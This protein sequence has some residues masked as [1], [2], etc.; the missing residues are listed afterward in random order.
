MLDDTTVHR[1]RTG[2]PTANTLIDRLI[3]AWEAGAPVSLGELLPP[4]PTAS[5]IADVACQEVALKLRAGQPVR[6]ADYLAR[7]PQ[8]ATANELVVYLLEAEVLGRKK[9]GP[10]PTLDEYAREFPHLL[11]ELERLFGAAQPAVPPSPEGYELLEEIGRGGMGVIY[12][13]RDKAL[14]REVAIK[15]LQDRFAPDS[16]VGRRFLEE[17]QITGQLQH[18]GI[19]AIHQVGALADGRPF[20]AMKLIKGQTL[21]ALIKSRSEINT[22]GVFESICQAVGYAH[23]RGVIHRDLKPENVMVGAFGEVQVMDWGLAKFIGAKS[24][25]PTAETQAA[26]P[27]TAIEDPRTP[28]RYD[29]TGVAGT[30]WYMAPEQ[31][32][33]EREKID[34]RT[35]VFALGGILCAMLTGK[36]PIEG[37]DQKAA[38]VNAVRGETTAAFARLDAIGVEQE[39]IG[40]CKRCLG[41]APD[42]RY[43]TA[44]EL[45]KA[46]AKL[47]AEADDRAKQAELYKARADERALAERKR[48]RMLLVAGLTVTCVLLVGIV[49]SLWQLSRANR[50]EGETAAQLEKTRQAEETAVA[51]TKTAKAALQKAEDRGN[52]LRAGLD[53][54]TGSIAGNYLGTQTVVSEEQK[55]FLTAILPLYRKLA[56]ESGNDEQ[57]RAR[58]ASASRRVGVIESRLGRNKEGVNAFY[59]ARDAYTR[60]ATDFPTVASYRFGLA[61]SYN[62][63]GV[64]LTM[65]GEWA[66][67]EAQHREGLGV[68]TNLLSAFPSDA[69]YKLGL[70][71]SHNNLGLLLTKLRKREAA[72]QQY[73]QGLAIIEKLATDFPDYQ[74]DLARSHSNLGVLLTEMGKWTEAEQQYRKSIGILLNLANESPQ[75]HTLQ[76]LARC[77]NNLGLLLADRG[78]GLEAEEECHKGLKLREKLAAIFP[79]Y[80]DYR[81]DLARS[82]TSLGLLLSGSRKWAKA[83]D[84]YRKGLT[85]LE[86]LVADFPFVPE[87]QLNS[88]ECHNS[89]GNTL[90]D[91]RKSVEAEEHYRKGIVLLEKVAANFPSDTRYI[92]ELAKFH[93]NYGGLLAELERWTE[94]EEQ[95][96]KGVALKEKL[97]DLFPTDPQAQVSLGSS[98]CNFGRMVMEGGNPANSLEWYGKA[99]R[100]LAPIVEAEL[101]AESAKQTLCR[102]YWGRA[103]A[104]DQLKQ[105][106]ASVKDW[107]QALEH[108]PSQMKLA[109]RARRTVSVLAAG[110][111]V[112]AVAE[113]AELQKLSG[114]NAKQLYDFACVYSMASGKIEDKKAEYANT[115]VQLLSKAVKAGYKDT[116]NLKADKQLDA[117]RERE[118]FKK[119][120]E[121]LEAKPPVAKTHAPAVPKK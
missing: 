51:E 92:S 39:L 112:E 41:F 6:V 21:A 56:R 23:E 104:N 83:E 24:T 19:P 8:V 33:G 71:T 4:D 105:Y 9:H 81:S 10:P 50:A 54:M 32:A 100:T 14:R 114:W 67:A 11:A 60:L 53:T 96:R 88:A 2:D 20:L 46:I 15:A 119:L 13:A 77:H 89:L 44:G 26:A 27:S 82:H 38:L 116:A 73:R 61:S 35:D 91:M 66:E 75:P 80:P 74:S 22:L 90:A 47:R 107:N 97:A 49:V 99:I 101:G 43:T 120:L 65:L 37:A 18:P 59:Q 68:F 72:E 28:E 63:L 45:A 62:D 17:A 106:D 1:S 76:D 117:L 95:H 93:N 121:D 52:D 86:K 85:I 111:A 113:V 87:H 48:R 55:K 94:A 69:T 42:V 70:V 103:E 25:S 7:Y 108:C 36:P 3:A 31:A 57:N 115:S 98:Y 110:R 102:S 40:L 58:V 12:R 64:A 79:A 29:Q 16:S 34:A 30:P 78:K 84:E 109:F 118:D 5:M